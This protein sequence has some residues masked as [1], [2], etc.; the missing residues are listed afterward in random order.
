MFK[1]V[2]RDSPN[3][4][5]ALST[6]FCSME[7]PGYRTEYQHLAELSMAPWQTAAP[8]FF[9]VASAIAFS[10]ILAVR[11]SIGERFSRDLQTT[12]QSAPLSLVGLY[13][14]LLLICSACS[15]FPH[16]L[17]PFELQHSFVLKCPPKDPAFGHLALLQLHG[18]LTLRLTAERVGDFFSR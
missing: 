15:P 12:K 8:T 4:S 18:A 10:G 5:G 9:S 14:N 6:A 7:S 1:K 17:L 16:V 3:C 13:D 2:S 11:A